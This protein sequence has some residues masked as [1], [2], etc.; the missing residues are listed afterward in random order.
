MLK[1]RVVLAVAVL[2]LVYVGSYI[3]LSRAAFAEAR[4]TGVAGFYFI[5]P[6][7]TDWWRCSNY[8]CVALYRP[9]IVLDNCLGTG[10]WPASEPLWGLSR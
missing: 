7:D 8:G 10:R 9:L 1:R 2:T 5:T 6:R 3:A 4:R